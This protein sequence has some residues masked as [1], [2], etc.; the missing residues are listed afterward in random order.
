VLVV[1]PG[2]ALYAVRSALQ[3]GAPGT[4]TLELEEPGSSGDA[5]LAAAEWL[6][7]DDVIVHSASGILL[8]GAE[9]LRR[10][11]AAGGG[12][13]DAT[14]FFCSGRGRG[15]STSRVSGVHV[16]SERILPALAEVTP[17]PDGR[18]L[19]EGV[20]RLAAAGGRVRAAVLESWRDWEDAARPAL[21]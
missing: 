18:S 10:T 1:G 19:L 13:A 7:G 12:H 11:F 9:P 21:A 2:E 4:V 15:I 17:G 6:D 16:F 20:D 8:R 5:L 3:L 14:V